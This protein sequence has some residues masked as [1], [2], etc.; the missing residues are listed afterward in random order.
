MKKLLG[1]DDADD[2][3]SEHKAIIE[4]RIKLYETNADNVITL[5]QLRRELKAEN[6]L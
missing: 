4:E 6:R 2:F 1:L 3:S 5:E